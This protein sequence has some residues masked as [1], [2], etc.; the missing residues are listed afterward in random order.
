MCPSYV[1]QMRRVNFRGRGSTSLM[2]T[3]SKLLSQCFRVRP[4]DG[5]PARADTAD[6]RTLAAD[7]KSALVF[8]PMPAERPRPTVESSAVAPSA[9]ESD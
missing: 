7:N 8:F 5:G 9:E 2:W 1:T 6:V 3:N 4:D